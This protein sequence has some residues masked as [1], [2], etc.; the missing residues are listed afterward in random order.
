MG[1]GTIV[2]YLLSLTGLSFPAYIGSMIIASVL[3]NISE[4]S[5]KWE[6]PMKEIDDIGNISLGIFLSIAMIS[7]KLW[8]LADLALPMLALLFAQVIL[9]YIFA[10]FII[11]YVMGKNY[12]AAIIAAG[13]CGFSMGATPNAMANM[14]SITSKH[15]PSIEAYLIVPIFGAVLMDFANVLV[16][17]LFINIF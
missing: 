16:I 14:D 10:R 17:T 11:F 1:I 12:D 5:K 15:G 8:L 3:R 2:S 13:A 4:Y 7:L 6:T 9:C